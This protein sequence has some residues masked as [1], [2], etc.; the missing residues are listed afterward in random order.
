MKTS[1]TIC[2]SSVAIAMTTSAVASASGT[3][4]SANLRAAGEARRSRWSTSRICPRVIARAG[5]GGAASRHAVER[6]LRRLQAVTGERNLVRFLTLTLPALGV[7]RGTLE[8]HHRARRDTMR[9]LGL[10]LLLAALVTLVAV[11]TASGRSGSA[12]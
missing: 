8:R 6:A 4:A 2:P 7:R 12:A 10:T 5:T 11:T 1:S 9:K 3:H